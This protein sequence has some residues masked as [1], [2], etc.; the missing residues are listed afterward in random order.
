M[1]LFSGKKQNFCS[2]NYSLQV[3]GYEDFQIVRHWIKGILLYML[4]GARN[5][6]RKLQ[7]DFRLFHDGY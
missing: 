3:L 4:T 5:P 1:K 6:H 2:W 7:Q